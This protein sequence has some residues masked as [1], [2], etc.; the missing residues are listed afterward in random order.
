MTDEK[1][2]TLD[3]YLP[4]VDSNSAGLLRYAGSLLSEINLRDAELRLYVAQMP[5]RPPW[6]EKI[7][8]KVIFPNVLGKSA[9][10]RI[11]VRVLRV[12]WLQFLYPFSRALRRNNS[13]LLLL[14]HESAPFPWWP[15]VAVVHDLNALRTDT[16][17]NG[18]F[19]RIHHQFWLS[20][21]NRCKKVI[22]ISEST[23][24]D[25]L[26]VCPKLADR[27]SVIHEGVDRSVFHDRST[28]NDGRVVK[29]L[30]G[31]DKY[32][33]YVGTLLGHKNVPFL[34]QVLQQLNSRSK[35]RIKLLLVGNHAES[36][37][38][39]LLQ[40]AR[41]RGVDEDLIF[42]GFLSDADLACILRNCSCF[43]FASL[44]EGFGLAP[45]EAMSCGAPVVS[46]NKGS[47][48]EVLSTGAILL[49]PK[50][51]VEWSG[52]VEELLNDES[53]SLKWQERGISR[54]KELSW[55]ETARQTL[56]EVFS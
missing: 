5:N 6:V 39:E 51:P 19:R 26:R 9:I 49:E 48:P 13:S 20:G 22:A 25:I 42:A 3:A 11:L 28:E 2:L 15:Q 54:A 40:I 4:Y 53:K 38:D 1:N 52:V 35:D 18:V 31:R 16:G 21:L 47:L 36:E 7:N 32:L 45:V 43:L 14:A 34:V 12:L 10:I 46:S 27:I 30:V 50:S 56:A 29:H 33:V 8:T 55:S 24:N 44:N 17:A 37:R 41:E 23:R